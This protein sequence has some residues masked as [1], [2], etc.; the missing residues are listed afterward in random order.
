MLNNNKFKYAVSTLLLLCFFVLFQFYHQEGD[1]EFGCS[2]NVS[3]DTFLPDESMATLDANVYIL[4]DKNKEGVANFNGTVV[5]AGEKYRVR[6][7]VNFSY[8]HRVASSVYD[9]VWKDMAIGGGDTLPPELGFLLHSNE[10]ESFFRIRKL[11]DNIMMIDKNG[12]PVM[13]CALK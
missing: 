5:Y 3:K 10:K 7:A 4:I 12:V 11:E 13:A 6:R 1:E 8:K 2:G 9:F